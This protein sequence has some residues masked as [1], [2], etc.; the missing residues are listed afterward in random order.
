MQLKILRFILPLLLLASTANAQWTNGLSHSAGGATNWCTGSSAAVAYGS[1]PVSPTILCEQWATGLASAC[2]AHFPPSYLYGGAQQTVS[3]ATISA[4][5]APLTTG[6]P[7]IVAV[8]HA[9]GSNSS[10][11][12]HSDGPGNL[13]AWFET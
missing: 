8:T 11:P 1:L 9:I 13:L 12:S 6:T 7:N 2:R 3:Q 5:F 10:V 4:A